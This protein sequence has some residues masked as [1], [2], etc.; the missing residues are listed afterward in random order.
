[1]AKRSGRG[2]YCGCCCWTGCQ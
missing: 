2:C 1:V